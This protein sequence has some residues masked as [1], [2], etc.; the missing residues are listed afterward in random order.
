MI[1]LKS[2]CP[3]ILIITCHGI[4]CCA[5][6]DAQY[7]LNEW[8]VNRFWKPNPS[9]SLQAVYEPLGSTLEAAYDFSGCGSE[10]VGSGVMLASSM[11]TG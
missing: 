6:V 8:T 7:F 2:P 11:M 9:H 10:S 5:T 3:N 1:S 4:P